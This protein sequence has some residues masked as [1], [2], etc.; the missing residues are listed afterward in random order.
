MNTIQRSTSGGCRSCLKGEYSFEAKSGYVGYVVWKDSIV[1]GVAV[2]L[3]NP[4]GL[5]RYYTA[6]LASCQAFSSFKAI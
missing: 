3:Y 2:G 5:N 4:G 6:I 1:I